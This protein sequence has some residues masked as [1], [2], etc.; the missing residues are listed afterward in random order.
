MAKYNQLNLG[1]DI[2]TNSVGWALLDENNNLIKKNGFTFWGVRMFEEANDSSSR[3]IFRNSRRR[4]RRRK[5]RLN[6]LQEIFASEI[7]KVDTTFFERL[8][9]SFYKQEDKK[10]NNYYNLFINEYTDKDF[11]HDYPTIYHLRKHLINSKKKEDIRFIYLACHNIIKYRG[12]FLQAGDS[13]NKSDNSTLKDMFEEFRTLSGNLS[14]Q[15]EEFENDDYFAAINVDINDS[16]FN[17]LGDILNSRLGKN[18]K[19][20]K[21]MQLFNVQK[22]S[23]AYDFL[24]ALIVDSPVS[25][26]KLPFVKDLGYETSKLEMGSCDDLDSKLGEIAD[27]CPDIY[28]L[29]MFSAKVKDLVDHFYLLKLLSGYDNLS[30]AMVDQYKIHQEDLAN[31]KKLIKKYLPNKYDECFKTHSDSLNNYAKYL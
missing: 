28:D 22:K 20:N 1:L 30:D 27:K 13:F 2:G 16:F 19:K 24:I 18:E 5:N 12:N 21:L 8:N 10:Y 17:N 9:D 7:N 15:F 11:F 6:Y 26:D 29:V 23:L 25:F 14:Q 31:L 3:R 4:I